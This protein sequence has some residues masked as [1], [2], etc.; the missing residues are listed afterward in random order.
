MS[1]IQN[2]LV[3]TLVL[4]KFI[5]IILIYWYLYVSYIGKSHLDPIASLRYIIENF[6][7]S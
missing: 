6:L 3:S 4:S 2:T 5:P 1:S 7:T